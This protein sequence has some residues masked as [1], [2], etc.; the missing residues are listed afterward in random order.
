MPTA[1]GKKSGGRQK[2]T[3][4]KRT[5]LHR[6]KLAQYADSA[7][8]KLAEKAGLIDGRPAAENESVQVTALRDICDRAWGKPTLPIADATSSHEEKL[9]ELEGRIGPH[10]DSMLESPHEE[11]TT[12]Q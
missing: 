10:I 11:H 5:L 1:D 6:K 7:L 9:R 12:V 2:G 3:P 4:N 8:E